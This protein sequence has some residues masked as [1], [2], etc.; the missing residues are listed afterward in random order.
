[1]Q[2]RLKGLNGE[3]DKNRNNIVTIRELYKYLSP[4][5]KQSTPNAQSPVFYGKFPNNLPMSYL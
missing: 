1:V 2:L 4:R 3:A 5:I